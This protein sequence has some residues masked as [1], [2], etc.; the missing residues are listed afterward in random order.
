MNGA[1]RTSIYML[2]KAVCTEVL[3]SSHAFLGLPLALVDEAYCFPN[4]MGRWVAGQGAL[5]ASMFLFQHLDTHHKTLL[6]A[7]MS[8]EQR[9]HLMHSTS[10]QLA[11]LRVIRPCLPGK[12]SLKRAYREACGRRIPFADGSW[13]AV[14][15]RFVPLPLRTEDMVFHC[16]PATY[17]TTLDADVGAAQE[18]FH[19]WFPDPEE[20][21]WVLRYSGRAL[22]PQ[23]AIKCAVLHCDTLGPSQAGHRGKTTFQYMLECVMG[24]GLCQLHPGSDL[25]VGTRFLQTRDQAVCLPLITAF[26]ELSRGQKLDLAALK[27]LTSGRP[28]APCVVIA[29]NPGDLPCLA[30]LV[31][32]DPAAYGRLVFLPARACLAARSGVHAEIDAL[33][34]AFAR[35]LLEQH[36]LYLAEGLPPPPASM[37]AHACALLHR[38]RLSIF[39]PAHV[40]FVRGWAAKQAQRDGEEPEVTNLI[41]ECMAEVLA[42]AR[43]Y[44]KQGWV[45][46]AGDIAGVLLD[47]CLA[48]SGH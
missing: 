44:H 33:I 4:C 42:M 10:L 38:S 22:V 19:E 16:L 39:H 35:L 14:G 3:S 41:S 26:D 23:D 2:G 43:V 21:L 9:G 28:P 25:T 29:C 6:G 12:H 8:S 1:T 11:L 37:A 46:G 31:E 40:R 15:Q 5:D 18:M 48:E 7:H 27:G 13:D 47:A 24:P 34:P 30:D 36:T 45:E 20:C 17:K 32:T